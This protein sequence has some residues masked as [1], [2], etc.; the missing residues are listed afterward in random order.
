ML[1]LSADDL[2]KEAV[3]DVKNLRQK[4]LT[5]DDVIRV[6][7][8][9]IN[10]PLKFAEK[11][12]AQKLLNLEE[13]IHQSLIDQEEAVKEVSKALRE[14]RAG[15]S[16]KGGPIATFLFVGPTGVGKTELSKI[17]ARIQFGSE[18]NMVSF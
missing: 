13:L 6:S 18:D 16:R 9:K 2:L 17:L 15:L 7:H 8:Q 1:P 5:G 12:E 11:E 10:V 3:A 14:Y 4:V